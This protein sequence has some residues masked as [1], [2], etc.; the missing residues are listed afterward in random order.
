M[1]KQKKETI[2]LPEPDRYP[3]SFETFRDIGAWE[4]GNLTQKQPDSVNG[5]VRVV[6]YKVTVEVIDEPIE[7]IHARIQEL[8]D[9][10]DNYHNWTPINNCAARYNYTLIGSAG[11][12]K[13]KNDI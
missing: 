7:V 2:S 8:W 10:C 11:S 9:K 12:K 3:F 5:W 13:N 1:A 6:K 4:K